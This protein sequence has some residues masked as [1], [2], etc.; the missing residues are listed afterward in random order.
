MSSQP[1]PQP[2]S[3]L[4]G[5]DRNVV[6]AGSGDVAL[7]LEERVQIFWHE[8]R[9]TVLLTIAAMLVVFVGKELVVLYLQERDR[10]IAAG[11]SAAGNDAA[12]LRTFANAHP[13]FGLAWLALADEAL[14]A[15]TY[16][17]AAADYQK[18]VDHLA[19]S[20]FAGRAAV[21]VAVSQALAGDRTKAEELL[22]KIAAD[23]KQMNAARAEANLHL[24]VLA[25]E[26]GRTKEAREFLIRI[27]VLDPQGALSQRIQAE[28]A[29]LPPE[30]APSAVPTTPGATQ[31]TPDI[32][33]TVPGKP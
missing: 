5:D 9:K 7:S 19:G 27:F 17:D 23:Q 30:E 11:F 13:E 2:K 10:T 26:A 3:K 18:A 15:G 20:P 16:A 24:A 8:N 21:G 25:R 31:A 33:L 12:K 1:T 32:K 4:A 6:A 28:M 22:K 29:N 14:K